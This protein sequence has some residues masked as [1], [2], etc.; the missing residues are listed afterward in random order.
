LWVG[1]QHSLSAQL[2]EAKARSEGDQSGPPAVEC[3]TAEEEEGHSSLH[4]EG[5]GACS[6]AWL[7]EANARAAGG[8]SGR[9]TLVASGNGEQRN[10]VGGRVRAHE[11]AMVLA[12]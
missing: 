4:S 2:G 10:D 5:G 1:E 12:I 8:A 9:F 3:P 7:V 11:M 6:S